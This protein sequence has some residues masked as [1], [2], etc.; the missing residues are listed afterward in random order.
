MSERVGA[1]FSESE[2][3][4]LRELV[5]EIKGKV[6]ELERA[7]AIEVDEQT[8]LKYQLMKRLH[9]EGG[10]VS[11]QRFN[12]LAEEVGYRDARGAQGVFAWGGKYFTMIAGERVAITPKGTSRLKEKG[13][14]A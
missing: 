3:E 4:R 14:I 1:E 12:E 8:P 10:V 9:D 13:L 2:Y 6:E 11:K 7:I 5:S